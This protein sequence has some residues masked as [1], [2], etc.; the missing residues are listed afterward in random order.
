[1]I[2]LSGYLFFTVAMAFSYFY[3]LSILFQTFYSFSKLYQ[4]Y[5]QCLILSNHFWHFFI[6]P[7]HFWRISYFL[8]L[9][10][11]SSSYFI[12]LS[13]QQ[14]HWA[15]LS[16]CLQQSK[17]ICRCHETALILILFFPNSTWKWQDYFRWKVWV[18]NAQGSLSLIIQSGIFRFRY[19]TNYDQ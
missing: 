13:Q 5:A 11:F 16:N 10:L 12:I 4:A 14:Q 15:F 2:I 1:V 18:I 3:A 19:I 17:D 7:H 6:L 8:Y 9:I